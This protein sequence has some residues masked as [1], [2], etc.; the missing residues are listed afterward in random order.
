[1]ERPILQHVVIEPREASDGNSPAILL[2]HGRGTNEQDLLGLA[3]YLDPR[4][5]VVSA[6]APFDFQWGPGYAW[7]DI[8]EVGY[9]DEEKF[10]ESC[11][12]II[13]LIELL[14]TSHPVDHGKIFLMGFSM[15]A[16]MASAVS[17]TRPDLVR[18]VVAHSGY[19]AEGEATK[20]RWNETA[21][22]RFFVAHGT[23]DP[24]IPVTFG[25]R[26]R[27]LLTAH[28]IDHTYTE[29]PIGHQISDASLRDFT[30]WVTNT[31]DES[32]K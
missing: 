5:L 13:N 8:I 30:T 17:L 16:V 19:I 11:D 26:A 25:R 1:M 23:E 7:Y 27:E 4:L 21:E 22:L 9:P 3:S 2:L 24:V 31:I 28:R 20:Y 14:K 12:R 10:P 29:Y 18:G 15:G 32:K 6:R